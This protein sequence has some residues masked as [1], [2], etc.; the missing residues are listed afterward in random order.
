MGCSPLLSRWDGTV[1][2][3]LSLDPMDCTPV[4]DRAVLR[5]ADYSQ[6]LAEISQQ[7]MTIESPEGILDAAVARLEIALTAK[8]LRWSDK[9][10]TPQRR[11]VYE[12]T[13]TDCRQAV[14]VQ[15]GPGHDCGRM[16]GLTGQS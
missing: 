2:P 6:L 4:A 7:V 16:T 11:F 9:E 10:I 3:F 5:R 12:T 14:E 8:H 13:W 1:P 15:F